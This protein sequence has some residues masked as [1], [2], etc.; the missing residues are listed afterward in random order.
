MAAQIFAEAAV[1]EGYHAQAFPYFGAERR[2]AP[3]RAFARVDDKRI[4]VKSQ[5]Y[6]PDMLVIM[7]ESLLDIDPVADGLKANG[8]AA[9]NTKKAPE[10]F[11]LGIKVRCATVDAIPI[12]LETIK[13]PIVNTAILGVLPKICDYV[14]LGSIKKAITDK[15]GEKL[16]E[17]AA[18]M[19]T[20]AATMA[21]ERC[22]LGL[23]K[24]DRPIVESKQWLPDWDHIPAGTALGP[25][26]IEGVM[27]G[28]GGSTQNYTGTWR[29]VTPRYIKEKC[30]RCLR[31]WFCCPEGCIKRLED[32]HVKWD[33]RYCKGCAICANVCPAE[34]IEMTKGVKEW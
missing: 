29:T 32:D 15:F 20:L 9:I 13:V 6:N 11:D 26:M 31:C 3:V 16:G 23:C 33:Y 2:G 22:R 4:T 24:G 17:Q 19:N 30:V 21:Y 12:A 7:D 34:A 25:E 10:E 5:I 14:T 1:L 28:P 8:L 27:I 18:L